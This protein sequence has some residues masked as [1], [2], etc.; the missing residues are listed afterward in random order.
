MVAAGGVTGR[1]GH[2]VKTKAV[3]VYY[4]RENGWTSRHEIPFAGA[5]NSLN[6]MGW[7]EGKA[8]GLIGRRGKTR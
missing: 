6:I 2:A 7:T 5:I 8:F 4:I 3:E 1:V